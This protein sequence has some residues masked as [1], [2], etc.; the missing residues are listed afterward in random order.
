MKRTNRVAIDKETIGAILSVIVASATFISL[1]ADL[2][3]L[4]QS[5]LGKIIIIIVFTITILYLS[6]FI[7]SHLLL[8]KNRINNKLD[9]I[10]KLVEGFISNPLH[11]VIN[12]QLDHE[13]VYRTVATKQILTKTVP[14]ENIQ[15]RIDGTSTI[16]DIIV[17]SGLHQGL[18][19]GMLFGIF[20]KAQMKHIHSCS[21]T[22]G[23]DQSTFTF[24][25]PP[26][27]PVSIHDISV[28]SLEIRPII[29]D[30]V[31]IVN[32][33]LAELLYEIDNQGG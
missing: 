11:T 30:G 12:E 28:D 27:C 3:Q 25:I 21:C 17:K 2:G 33:F 23:Y 29:P 18:R 31:T 32:K 10:Q 26:N 13:V 7:Y 5:M 20:Y 14:I 22:V 15:V 24:T 4:S 9:K 1:V 16:V 8:E 19:D 6:W